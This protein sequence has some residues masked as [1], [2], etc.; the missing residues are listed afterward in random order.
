MVQANRLSFLVL[1]S[2]VIDSKSGT[3]RHKSF[4]IQD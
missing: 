2:S 3:F 4:L 1:I